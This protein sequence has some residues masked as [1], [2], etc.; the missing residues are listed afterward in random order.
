MGHTLQWRGE[1]H[2]QEISEPLQHRFHY[3][4]V[5][6]VCVTMYYHTRKLMPSSVAKI[7][8]TPVPISFEDQV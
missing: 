2:L 1:I 5:S 7:L 6:A 4:E 3:T 8:Q